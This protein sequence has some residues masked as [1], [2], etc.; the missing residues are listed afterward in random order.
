MFLDVLDA[1]ATI[2]SNGG[3]EHAAVVVNPPLQFLRGLIT[4]RLVWVAL[5][6][7]LA[8]LDGVIITRDSEIKLYHFGLLLLSA[9]S[10]INPPLHNT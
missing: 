7:V 5:D 6:L 8:V 4:Q 1:D 3:F 2:G 9:A 10:Q